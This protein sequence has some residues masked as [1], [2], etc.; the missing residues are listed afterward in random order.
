MTTTIENDTTHLKGRQLAQE[1]IGNLKG[2]LGVDLLPLF[3]DTTRNA[4]EV[5]REIVLTLFQA[6]VARG[7]NSEDRAEWADGSDVLRTFA[8]G[9]DVEPNL[10]YSEDNVKHLRNM[11]GQDIY[12]YLYS[13]TKRFENMSKA[14]SAGTLALQIVGGGLLSVGIPMAIGTFKALKDGMALAA[15]LRAGIANIGMKTA[16]LAVTVALATFLWWLF[17]DNPKKFLGMVIND[18]DDHLV[19][20]NWR[21]GTDGAKGADLYMDHGEMLAFPQDYEDG[22]LG[23]PLQINA[24][25]YFGPGDKD[26]ASYAG[27]FFAEKNFGGYGAEGIIVFSPKGGT[28]RFAQL[29][30]CPY[31]KD[32]GTAVRVLTGQ[33][34]VPKLFDELYP[35]RKVNDSTIAHGYEIVSSV[36]D[37]RG[38]IIAGISCFRKV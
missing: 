24:R 7:E 33:P 37:A 5:R 10:P 15:A 25:A 20:N 30:A 35:K 34:D 17:H 4:R 32:N 23:K 29:F 11:R 18:T 19:V 6:L 16:I 22:N 12:D 3:N 27:I 14:T 36:N 31:T 9:V 13:L 1:I 26:N 28:P 2:D 8:T 38:G 21:A